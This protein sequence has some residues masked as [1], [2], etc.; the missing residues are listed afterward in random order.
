MD[1]AASLQ[2]RYLKSAVTQLGAWISVLGGR[3]ASVTRAQQEMHPPPGTRNYLEN[4]FDKWMPLKKTR[5]PLVSG[6]PREC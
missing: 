2:K 6:S 5:T 3:G 1:P 4:G